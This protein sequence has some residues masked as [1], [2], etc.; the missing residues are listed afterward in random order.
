VDQSGVLT[1]AEFLDMMQGRFLSDG[2][3]KEIFVTIDTSNDS[4]VDYDEWRYF[5]LIFLEPFMKFDA[6]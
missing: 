3:V 2:E 6:D 1:Q 5:F 4:T